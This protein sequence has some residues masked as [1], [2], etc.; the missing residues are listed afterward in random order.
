MRVFPLMDLAQLDPLEPVARPLEPFLL[1]YMQV[2]H[3][4]RDVLLRRPPWQKSI[5]LKANGEEPA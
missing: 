1:R 5:C 2:F 3:T 4:E